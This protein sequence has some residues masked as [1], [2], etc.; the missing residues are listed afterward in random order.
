MVGVLMIPHSLVVAVE[1]RLARA[2]A[3]EGGRKKRTMCV[4]RGQDW[5]EK[6]WLVCVF[7]VALPKAGMRLWEIVR[8]VRVVEG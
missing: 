4:G 7:L 5:I 8:K 1:I 3:G 6:S 2:V